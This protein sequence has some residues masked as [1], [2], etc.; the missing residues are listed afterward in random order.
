MQNLPGV[1][2]PILFSNLLGVVLRE[3]QL[4]LAFHWEAENEGGGNLH[5]RVTE[6]RM[7]LQGDSVEADLGLGT[8]ASVPFTNFVMQK[9]LFTVFESHLQRSLTASSC[10]ERNK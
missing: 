5:L 10:A 3:E 1:Y 9:K 4:T 6:R 2:L 7:N 8:K